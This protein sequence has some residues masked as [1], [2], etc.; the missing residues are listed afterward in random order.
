METLFDRLKP[1]IKEPLL[2]DL[3]KYPRLIGSIIETLKTKKAITD[4]T[5]GEIGDIK[6][7][8]PT[9]VTEIIQIWEMFEDLKK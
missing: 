3:D 2:K 1:E 9:Y 8:S 7:Y 4:L 5:I 6:S